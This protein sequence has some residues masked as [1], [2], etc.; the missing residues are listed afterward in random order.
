[1]LGC[2]LLEWR[3]AAAREAANAVP[4]NCL[5]DPDAEEKEVLG[6]RGW[7]GLVTMAWPLESRVNATV[8]GS[9]ASAGSTP[10]AAAAAGGQSQ[11]LQ[12]LSMVIAL[13]RDTT[14]A[15][16]YDAAAAAV[17]TAA[18]AAAAAGSPKKKKG[19]KKSP[20]KGDS[21]GGGG[22]RGTGSIQQQQQRE[23]FVTPYGA[24]W[25]FHQGASLVGPAHFMA[26]SWAALWPVFLRA[27]VQRSEEL[28]SQVCEGVNVFKLV[29]VWPSTRIR[30]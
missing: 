4:G 16:Q 6:D 20:S 27:A 17:A 1:M 30:V 25:Q 26:T 3:A 11:S 29:C 28:V 15:W 22:N 12:K 10:A 14:T 7:A 13:P 5:N 23:W 2:Y 18:V 21:S 9:T 19:K 24:A 8:M